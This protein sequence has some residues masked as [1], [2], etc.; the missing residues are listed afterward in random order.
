MIDEGKTREQSVL[1]RQNTHRRTLELQALM[2]GVP[3]IIWIAH[4]PECLRITGNRAACELL[5]LP[6]TA[7]LS[8]TAPE[9]ERPLHFK[10]LKNGIEIPLDELPMQM[11]AKGTEIRNCEIELLFD[12]GESRYVLGN[13]TPLVDPKGKVYGSIGAFVE[14][15]GQKR[16][17]N[18]L[19]AR[20]ERYR[21]FFENSMDAIMVGLPDE[22][23]IIA[24]NPQASQILGWTEEELCTLGRHDI[25][26]P[27]DSRFAEMLEARDRVGAWRGELTY[28]RKDGTKFP[29]DLSSAVVRDSQGRRVSIIILRDITERKRMEHELSKVRDGLDMRVQERTAELV[30]AGQRLREQAALLDLAHDAIFVRDMN[31]RVAFWNKAAEDTFGFTREQA[32]GKTTHEL[33][34]TRFPE[35]LDTIIERVSKDGRW[36][37]ELKHLTSTGDEVIADSRWAL[38]TGPDGNATG[39]LEIDRNITSRKHSEELLRRADRAFR[40]LSECN[41]ALVR[42]TQE[43]ELLHHVCRTIVE[44]GGYRMAWVGFAEEDEMKTVRPVAS[45]GHEDGYLQLANIS[46]ADNERGRGP[47]GRAVRTGTVNIAKEMLINSDFD[48]WRAN[49][50]RRGYASSIALPLIADKRPFGS[51]TIYAPEPDAFDEEEVKF[52]N[53]LAENLSYGIVSIRTTIKRKRAEDE[54]R[55]YTAKLELMNQELQEFAFIASHDLQE[56]LR[57]IQIFGD[58][59]RNTHAH[60]LDETAKDYLVRMGSAANRMQQLIQELLKYSRVATK[61]GPFNTVNLRAILDEVLQIFELQIKKSDGTVEISEMPDIEAD[62]TQ[63]KQLFQNLIGNALKFQ[64]PGGSPHVKVRSA[65][66]AKNAV[67]IMVEDNGIGFEERY[68]DRIFAPFQRLH[69]RSEYEG[70]GMGLAICRKILERHHGSITAKSTPGKGSTFI[71]TLPLKQK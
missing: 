13:A 32:L 28:L 24:A 67:Q 6:E 52:L 59:L 34:Q 11:A 3:G 22:N 20:E 53:S 56:P 37:G 62:A 40:T 5:R 29:A 18:A 71:I 66:H 30:K 63:M 61:P 23:R 42:E 36:E 2:D 19:K 54:L 38:Q 60:K 12:D 16:I 43:S 8:R 65:G 46:W 26:D 41:Q 44:V 47:T 57:K 17:Q 51:L 4:D 68:L 27:D 14:I 9:S 70:T 58:R 33:L 25:L 21:L 35:P 31:D 55:L 7:N 49:A 15:T 50:I 39:I 48:Y 45:A 69:A 1:R 64:R 10:A